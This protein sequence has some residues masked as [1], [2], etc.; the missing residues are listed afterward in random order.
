MS[1]ATIKMANGGT[2]IELNLANR[3][4]FSL[5]RNGVEVMWPGGAPESKRPKTGWP[6]SEI[7]MF[8]IIGAAP[9]DKIRIGVKFLDAGSMPIA[10]GGI[11]IAADEEHSMGSSG[12]N[13]CMTLIEARGLVKNLTNEEL[14]RL[15]ASTNPAREPSGYIGKPD[16]ETEFVVL[17]EK[18]KLYYSKNCI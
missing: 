13:I 3:Q 7:V 4:L 6:N 2:E 17:T 14:G 10:L 1:E 5:K 9:D 11:V 15:I 12:V 8:P 16:D 18:G